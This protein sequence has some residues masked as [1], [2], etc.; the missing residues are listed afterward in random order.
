[1]AVF[2]AIVFFPVFFSSGKKTLIVKT[3]MK[4]LG[5]RSDKIKKNLCKQ[6]NILKYLYGWVASNATQ[7]YKPYHKISRL[8]NSGLKI[9]NLT[10][11][12]M[13]F[14][15][16]GTILYFIFRIDMARYGHAT[17][18]CKAPIPYYMKFSRHFNFANLT[19]S[20]FATLKFRDFWKIVNF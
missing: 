16:L 6:G 2:T 4:R 13:L 8:G 12:I 5:N 3:A 18:S 10:N 15:F 9:G 20:Y 1:M 11:F 19:W 7:P 17:Q 14:L